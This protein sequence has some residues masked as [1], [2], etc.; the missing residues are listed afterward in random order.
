VGS[1]TA[2]AHYTG[3][4]GNGPH[5]AIIDDHRIGN[6]PADGLFFGTGLQPFGHMILIVAAP[7]EPIGLNFGCGR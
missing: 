3:H 7:P 6:S 4:I 5:Q 2:S 1:S